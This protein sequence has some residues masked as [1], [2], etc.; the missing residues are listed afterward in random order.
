MAVLRCYSDDTYSGQEWDTD[1]STPGVPDWFNDKMTSF[2][3]LDEHRVEFFHDANYSGTMFDA[4]G[5]YPNDCPGVQWQ[6]NDK[7]TSLKLYRKEG[8]H[9]VQI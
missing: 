7:M 5:K 1:T 6:D 3:L 2:H 8:N 9:W 4:P